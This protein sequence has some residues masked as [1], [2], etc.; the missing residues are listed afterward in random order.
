MR[1]KPGFSGDG[2]VYGDKEV[3]VVLECAVG[4][5]EDAEAAR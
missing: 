3:V 5:H 4:L 2:Q 1:M